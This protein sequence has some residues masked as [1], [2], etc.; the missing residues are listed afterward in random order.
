MIKKLMDVYSCTSAE[1]KYVLKKLEEKS[2]PFVSLYLPST[3]HYEW[4]K[5]ANAR[6]D[7]WDMI[8]TAFDKCA[9]AAAK[10]SINSINLLEPITIHTY[11]YSTGMGEEFVLVSSVILSSEQ[12][13]ALFMI[14]SSFNDSSIEEI[15]EDILYDYG[16]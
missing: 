4:I 14:Y 3:S 12:I 10:L 6:E 5:W 15:I 2:I 13:T 16:R 7:D 1:A 9:Y 11:H 8:R